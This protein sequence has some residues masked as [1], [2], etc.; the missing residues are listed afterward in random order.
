MKLNPTDN[1]V[2]GSVT[3]VEIVLRPAS[4][5]SSG[6]ILKPFNPMLGETFELDRSADLGWRY[7]AEQVA[8]CRFSL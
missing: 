3:L 5:A 7:A 6:R 1:P 8:Q 2:P 4:Y